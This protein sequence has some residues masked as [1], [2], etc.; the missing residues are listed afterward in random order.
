M[1][2]I[3]IFAIP[4]TQLRQAICATSQELALMRIDKTVWTLESILPPESFRVTYTVK[5]KF[6]REPILN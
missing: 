4:G 3:F 6:T 1:S 2:K 5:E